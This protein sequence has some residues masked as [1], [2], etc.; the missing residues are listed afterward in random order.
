MIK[1]AWEIKK[2]THQKN[3]NVMWTDSCQGQWNWKTKG[4]IFFKKYSCYPVDTNSNN[5]QVMQLG[6]QRKHLKLC[7]RSSGVQ[8]K[9]QH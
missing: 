7:C 2:H 4:K 9:T 8:D 5:V 3:N 1:I 6:D